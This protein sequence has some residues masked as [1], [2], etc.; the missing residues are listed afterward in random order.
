MFDSNKKDSIPPKE[1]FEKFVNFVEDFKQTFTKDNLIKLS[2]TSNYPQKN[3]KLSP[4]F[5]S[6]KQFLGNSKVG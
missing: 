2:E 4:M 5:D 6:Y 1:D 3:Q